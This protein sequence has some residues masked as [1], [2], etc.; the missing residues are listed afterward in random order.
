MTLTADTLGH[1]LYGEGYED[2]QHILTKLRAKDMEREVEAVLDRHARPFGGNPGKFRNPDSLRH[3]RL[4]FERKISEISVTLIS[5]A[6]WVVVEYSRLFHRVFV[7][8]FFYGLSGGNPENL[9]C[10]GMI[11]NRGI[12]VFV[13]LSLTFLSCF[14][15]GLFF[16]EAKIVCFLLSD[17]FF[18]SSSRTLKG[19]KTTVNCVVLSQVRCR[20]ETCLFRK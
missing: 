16:F 2:F 4:I 3:L 18:Q 15:R 12:L 20:H 14:S 13:L 5:S 7:R 8:L 17:G 9:R 6:T 11:S 19:G 10:L 1:D